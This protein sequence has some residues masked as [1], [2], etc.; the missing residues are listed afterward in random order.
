MKRRVFPL[1]SAQRNDARRMLWVHSRPRVA[2][3][4][5]Q[6][7]LFS[8]ATAPFWISCRLEE[9]PHDQERNPRRFA[10]AYRFKSNSCINARKHSNKSLPGFQVLLGYLLVLRNLD[11]GLG[12]GTGSENQR[13]MR[14]ASSALS[15]SRSAL[16]PRFAKILFRERLRF[17]PLACR[18]GLELLSI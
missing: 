5:I 8:C 10:A 9:C 4:R 17:L 2:Q 3:F 7:L 6:S 12:V 11:K 13:E 14:K 16:V 1:A 15:S 18:G